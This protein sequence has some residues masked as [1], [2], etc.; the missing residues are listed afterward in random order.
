MLYSEADGQLFLHVLGAITLF[1]ATATVAVLA[2]FGRHRDV[3]LPLA[4]ASF[5]TLLVLGIPAWVVTL[6]FGYWTKSGMN[7][8]DGVGWIDIGEGIA[9]AGLLFLLVAGA[10]SYAW[11]RRPV[12]GWPV[13]ALGVVSCAYVAALAVAWWVMSAK[14]PT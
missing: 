11:M 6:A 9:D 8:P 12:R 7:W 2:L 3:Q 4:R 14:V 5:F 13:T 1:G 10:L